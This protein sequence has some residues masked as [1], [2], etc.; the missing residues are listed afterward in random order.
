MQH[1]PCAPT[2]TLRSLPTYMGHLV[3][4]RLGQYYHRSPK[5]LDGLMYTKAN[6]GKIGIP[7]NTSKF[8]LP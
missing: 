1:F 5:I 2:L 8:N 3:P 6:L 7:N 4:A